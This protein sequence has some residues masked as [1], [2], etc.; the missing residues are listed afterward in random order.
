M[1]RRKAVLL[2]MLSAILLVTFL[3]NGCFGN[4][5]VI[6]Q[7]KIVTAY[8]FSVASVDDGIAYLP[9]VN[10]TG[11]E[12]AEVVR[13]FQRRYGKVTAWNIHEG[14]RGSTLGLIVTYNPK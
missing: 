3:L 5:G 2:L 7:T 6:K 4:K 11:P 12:A 1:R 14:D 13:E 10:V 8:D 9:L